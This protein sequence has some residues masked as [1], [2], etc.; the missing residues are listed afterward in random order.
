[1][2][3]IIQSFLLIAFINF[4]G[5]A[6]VFNGS[7][8]T[9]DLSSEPSGAKVYVN[10]LPEGKTPLKLTLKK[11]KEYILEFKLK[12]YEDKSLRLSYSLAAGWLIADILLTFVGLIVDAITGAWY[13]LDLD[14]YK[15]NLEPISK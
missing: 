12:D 13:N 1:M 2:N 11:G 10:G 6:T 9:I 14:A 7:S 4:I 5:C 15:A 3:K 8:D